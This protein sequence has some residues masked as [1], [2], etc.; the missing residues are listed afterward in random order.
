MAGAHLSLHVLYW[1]HDIGARE[2][3]IYSSVA[4][5]CLGRH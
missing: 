2:Q 3:A 1:E 5:A 4:G